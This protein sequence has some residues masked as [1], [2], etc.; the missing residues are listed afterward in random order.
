LSFSKSSVEIGY[1]MISE[2][3]S[4]EQMLRNAQRAE[5]AGFKFAMLSDHFHPWISRQGNSAFAWSILGAL[6]QATKQMRFATGVTCP[7]MRYHPAIIAQAAATMAVMMPNRFSLGLGTGENLNEHIIGAGWPDFDVRAAMLEE[8]VKIIRML[9]EGGVQTYY[10][11]Y[12]TIE[13]A[14]LYTLP[15]QLPEILIAASGPNAAELAGEIGD[16]L[17]TTSPKPEVINAFKSASDRKDAPCYA[18]I[19]ACYAEDVDKAKKFV[20]EQWPI[21][22]LPGEL[23]QELRT[24]T[25]FEQA[26]QLVTEEVVAKTVLIGNDPEPHIKRIQQ[27][28]DLGINKVYIHQIGPEQ[29]GFMKFY[30]KE[31]MPQFQE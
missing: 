20:V 23:D 15:Q 31:I 21:A 24:P 27:C 1:A 19:T 30:Q 13:N 26:A 25:H 8:A 29:E 16:G 12:Y 14:R 5:E 17:I 11:D 9:F 6:S 3:H 4:P 28:K 2:E 18:Y 7:I 10:G 22:G